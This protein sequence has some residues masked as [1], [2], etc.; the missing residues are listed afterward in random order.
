M[1]YNKLVQLLDEFPA[2]KLRVASFYI[3]RQFME[4]IKK[5]HMDKID[6]E[7]RTPT[8]GT[9][10]LLESSPQVLFFKANY[11]SLKKDPDNIKKALKNIICPKLDE[12]IPD[13]VIDLSWLKDKN[14]SSKQGDI[15]YSPSVLENNKSCLEYCVYPHFD[16]IADQFPE[17]KN[18]PKPFLRFYF[19]VLQ[20]AIYR[21]YSFYIEQIAPLKPTPDNICYFLWIGWLWKCQNLDYCKNII[22]DEATINRLVNVL[23]EPPGFKSK[24]V[25]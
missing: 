18:V 8:I 7:W 13:Y 23:P 16:W 10:I 11:W 2:E 19:L 15:G 5:N 9:G 22:P 17:F 25:A 20:S 3:T 12:E 21:E 6:P 4:F 24:N 1:D 14:H